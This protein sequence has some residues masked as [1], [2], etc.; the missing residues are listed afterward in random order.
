[1]LIINSTLYERLAD[2][3]VDAI[4][5]K[6]FYSDAIYF[7]DDQA[8]Y[9]FS[10]TLMIYYREHRFPERNEM[11]VENIVPVWWE[12]HSITSEGELLNDF[13]FALLNLVICN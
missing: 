3:L 5:G 8:Q 4:D 10:A 12:F 13:D 11:Q 2:L 1:M 7:E 6:E 9:C